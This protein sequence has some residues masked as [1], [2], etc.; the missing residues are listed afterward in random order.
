MGAPVLGLGPNSAVCPWTNCLTS[1]SLSFLVNKMGVVIA[2]ASR[3]V[4]GAKVGNA[5]RVLS[6][7]TGTSE[8]SKNFQISYF[9]DEMTSPNNPVEYPILQME[10]QTQ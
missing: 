8:E 2:P 3:A 7:V 10:T 4:V 6:A 1:L 5:Y 9:S